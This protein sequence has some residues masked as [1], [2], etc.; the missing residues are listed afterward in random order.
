MHGFIAEVA[1]C[2]ISNA[3]HQLE[4]GGLG[5]NIWI[6][7]NGP[8]DIA[9]EGILIQQKFCEAGGNLS[10]AAIKNIWKPILTSLAMAINI[11]FLGI[12]MI[13]WLN[14]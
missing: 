14:F 6:D 3:R 2:G 12:T 4:H 8:A 10:L 13:R 1:E 9:R 5:P 11:K 7:D